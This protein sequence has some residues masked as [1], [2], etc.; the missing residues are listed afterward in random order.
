MRKREREGVIMNKVLTVMRIQAGEKM[1]SLW[2]SC[3]WTT[4]TYYVRIDERVVMGAFN[5]IGEK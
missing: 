1:K 4:R 2:E 5:F 3:T